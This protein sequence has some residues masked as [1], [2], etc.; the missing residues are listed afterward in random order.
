MTMQCSRLFR[1][2]LMTAL[3]PLLLL[4]CQS[5]SKKEEDDTGLTQMDTTAAED[6]EERDKGKEGKAVY[7]QVPAPDELFQI[8]DRYK[9]EP[10]EDLLNDPAAHQDYVGKKSKALNFGIYSTDLAYSSIFDMGPKALEYFKVVEKL[11]NELEISSAFSEETMK[12]IEKNLGNSDSLASVSKETYIKAYEYLEKNDRGG[13]LAMVVAGGSI[14]ALYLLTH[15]VDEK[16]FDPEDKMVQRIAEQKLLLENL[17]GFMKKYEGEKLVAST[18]KDMEPVFDA[19]TALK[20]EG[21]GADLKEGKGDRPVLGG[22]NKILIT[23]KEFLSI[24]EK[25][26]TLR[27]SITGVQEQ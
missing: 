25:V 13:T 12:T 11:G 10:Q 15:M 5:G 17:K 21:E 16:S 7:Y 23:K 3:V 1:L 19:F 14:E 6:Q 27:N 20:E 4:G 8:I 2:V 24:R 22:G 18:L 9:E 26:S